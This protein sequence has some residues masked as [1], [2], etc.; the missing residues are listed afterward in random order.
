[1]RYIRC[2]LLGWTGSKVIKYPHVGGH[3]D[4]SVDVACSEKLERVHEG[5]PVATSGRA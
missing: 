3:D 1:M 4:R 5:D 2:L